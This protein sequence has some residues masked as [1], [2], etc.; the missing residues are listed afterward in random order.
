MLLC[1]FKTSKILW[2]NY[3]KIYDVDG[4]LLKISFATLF[5]VLLISILY[6]VSP[7]YLSMMAKR[8]VYSSD[9]V[10]YDYIIPIICC[11]I[12]VY[13]FYDDYKDNTYELI[14]F[15]NYNKFNYIVIIRWLIYVSIFIV[16]S[17]VT[18]LI[19]YRTESFFSFQNVILSLRFIPNLII[20]TSLILLITTITKNIYAA[21]F[22]TIS[23][24][25]CDYLSLGHLFRIFALGANTNNFYYKISPTYYMTNRVLLLIIGFLNV[26][27]SGKFASK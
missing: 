4:R 27:I 7:E 5:L 10:M 13:A 19:Y 14:A 2:N 16:G 3:F 20:L 25:M 24:A 15:L 23:Y 8:I 11:S 17:F 1:F 6:P 12:I 9:D 26:Y 18:G 22:L 21:I